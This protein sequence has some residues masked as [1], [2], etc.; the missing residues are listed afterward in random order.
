VGMTDMFRKFLET[1][2]FTLICHL[3]KTHKIQARPFHCELV[4]FKLLEA[5]SSETASSGSPLGELQEP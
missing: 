1:F 4:P 5:A 3:G 2:T